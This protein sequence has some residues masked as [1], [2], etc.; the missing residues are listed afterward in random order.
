MNPWDFGDVSVLGVELWNTLDG[1]ET[2]ERMGPEW[3]TYEVHADKHDLQ[4]LGPNELILATDGGAYRTTDHGETW[5]DIEA[6]PIGQFYHVTHIPWAPG[7]Y[8]AARAGQRHEY[9]Q[10][11]CGDQLDARPRR[12][13]L[14]RVVP[15]Q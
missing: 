9:G 11:F 4:W 14:H 2:W 8:T 5:Q 1:G 7:W 6:L 12:R 13:W 3:W 10:R 15:S